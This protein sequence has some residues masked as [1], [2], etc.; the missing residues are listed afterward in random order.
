MQDDWPS[1]IELGVITRSVNVEHVHAARVVLWRV[2][3]SSR[4]PNSM[5]TSRHIILLLQ[6]LFSL[7]ILL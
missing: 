5:K 4:H 3:L 2:H 7:L 1:P 6:K